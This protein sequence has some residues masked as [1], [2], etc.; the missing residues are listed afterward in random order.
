MSKV[1]KII[2]SGC[3]AESVVKRE[4]VYDGFKKIGEKF[5][6][7]ACGRQY[8]SEEE[9]PV[10]TGKKP[11][12]FGADDMPKKLDIFKEDEKGKSCR[13]C[14]NYIVNPFTQ[15]CGLHDKEVLAT[16]ICFDFEVKKQPMDGSKN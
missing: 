1:M 5:T 4:P 16:D 11:G 2:C 9:L 13:Y 12:I 10:I 15:R 8:A 3:G 7:V 6:C 14:R